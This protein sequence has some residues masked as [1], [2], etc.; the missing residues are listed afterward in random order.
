MKYFVQG[1]MFQAFAS[2]NRC[3]WVG[4]GEIEF[5]TLKKNILPGVCT[6][7]AT[8]GGVKCVHESNKK[9]RDHKG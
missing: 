4:V 8:V 5:A 1:C 9:P 2:K 3:V 7:V 6:Q